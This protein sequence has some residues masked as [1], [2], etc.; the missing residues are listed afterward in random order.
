MVLGRLLCLD[1][2][3][4]EAYF[5]FEGDDYIEERFCFAASCPRIVERVASA[6]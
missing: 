2:F 1:P 6:L 3:Y 5:D 4:G